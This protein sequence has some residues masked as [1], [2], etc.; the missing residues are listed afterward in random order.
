MHISRERYG[1]DDNKHGMAWVLHGVAC[2]GM[3][4]YG[5]VVVWRGVVVTWRSVVRRLTK[6]CRV[7]S[8]F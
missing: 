3:A 7:F 6:N 5:V 4:C 1:D 2:C 8:E